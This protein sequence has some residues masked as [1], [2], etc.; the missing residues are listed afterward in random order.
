MENTKKVTQD[1]L[2]LE[3]VNPADGSI[4]PIL[5]KETRYPTDA[6]RTNNLPANLRKVFNP[7]FDSLTLESLY[8]RY[9]SDQKYT[10][11][12]RLIAL[13]FLVNIT[14]LIFYIIGFGKGDN[15]QVSRVVIVSLFCFINGI[16]LGFY[17]CNI[18]RRGPSQRLPYLAWIVIFVQLI[19]NLSLG[20]E[21][22]KASDSLGVFIFFIYVTYVMLPFRLHSSLFLGIIIMVIHTIIV[23]L[24]ARKDN[25]GEQVTY[26]CYFV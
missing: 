9:F 24:F 23:A 13:T 25:M 6:E 4:K 14:L 5:R 18:I 16:M 1:H 19:L 8:R 10:S 22:L 2:E 20:Y 3:A 11:L 15:V 26:K 17:G 21:P 7:E 12:L